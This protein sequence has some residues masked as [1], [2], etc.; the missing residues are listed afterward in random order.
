MHPRALADRIESDLL[1]KM[2]LVSGPRQSG[3]TTLARSILMRRHKALAGRY[4]N[5]DDDD[6]RTRILSKEF[7]HTGTVVFDE[8]H[9]FSRWRN[10][11]KGLYD[12][13]HEA[14]Q[15]LV[16]GSARLDLYRRGGDSMQGR[17]HHLRLYP[18]SLKEAG[19]RVGDLM[20]LGP[21][22]EPLFAGSAAKA[23]R[24]SRE[25][26]TRLIR[27]DVADLERIQE[28]GA[29]E[30]LSMRLPAL[31]GSPLSLNALREGLQVAHK[32]V[33]RWVGVLERLLFIFRIT[34][35]GPPRIK[36]AKK[37]SKH[38]HFDW[39]TVADEGSRFENLIGFH[40]LKECHFQEDAEG[41]DT[42]LRFFRDIEGR[43]VDFV[44]MLDG[45]PVRFVECKLAETR[46][47]PSL[48]YLHRKFP[49]VDAIQVV[50]TPRIDRVGPL[51]IRIVSADRFLSELNV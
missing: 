21:F 38:Y 6:S 48:L 39:T 4:M 3:K 25:Y 47:D 29:L 40:L 27:D 31:V 30:Q 17:Y 13:H 7:P 49:R 26:R 43:E 5:W 51:G 22:P 37:S 24:W 10:F 45:K 35:F 32:T 28:L 23:K 2:V 1:E 9:K 41:E 12:M 46:V 11:L 16:T 42:E 19:C 18:F 36:A 44:Q 15:V 20:K 8:L 50:A 14:L 33:D 34:P